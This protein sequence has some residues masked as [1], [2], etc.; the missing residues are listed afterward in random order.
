[1]MRDKLAVFV[2]ISVMIYVVVDGRFRCDYGHFW[3]QWFLM[4]LGFWFVSG[5][6]CRV[7]EFPLNIRVQVFIVNL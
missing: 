3:T 1:M 6:F 5:Y 2:V 7:G 4:M